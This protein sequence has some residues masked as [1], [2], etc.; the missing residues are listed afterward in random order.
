MSSH[1]SLQGF[2]HPASVAIIGAKDDPNSVGGRPIFYMRRYGYTGRIYPVNPKRVHVQQLTCFPNLNSLPEQPDLVIIAVSAERALTAVEDAVRAGAKSIIMMSSGFGE[3]G[4]AGRALEQKIIR[5]AQ[6]AGV[7][8][9]GPNAQGIA[10][11]S[12]GAI[13]NFSTMFMEIEPEDGPIAIVSQ[14]GAASVM[15]YALLR[16]RGIGARYLAAT[17][18]DADITSS[19]LLLAVLEDPEIKL[20]LLYLESIRETT[21][22]ASAA[23][24]ARRKGVAIVALKSGTSSRG[25]SAASSHTGALATEDA[26]VDAYFRRHGIYRVSDISELAAAAELYLSGRSPGKGR[27]LTM[28]HS[29]AVGVVCADAAEQMGMD[30]ADLSDDTVCGLRDIMPAFGAIHNP[31]DL[32]AGLLSDGSLFGRA[33]E[34]LCDDSNID[35]IHIGM[36]VAGPGYDVNGFAQAARA[37]SDRSGKLILVSGPQLSVLDHFKTQGIPTY[38]GDVEALGLLHQ[39]IQHHRL[40]QQ[41]I[42]QAVTVTELAMPATTLPCLSEAD[43]LKLMTDLG[44]PVVQHARCHD[45]DRA[46]TAFSQIEGKVVLKA[47]SPEIPHKSEYNLVWLGIE[48]QE[49]LVEAFNACHIKLRQLGFPADVIVARQESGR[50]EIVLGARR[51]PVF[52][53]VV[54]IG[55]GG[56]YLEVLKDYLL[57]TPP[58]T[59]VEVLDALQQLRIWP[60]L[61]GVRGD[62]PANLQRLCEAAVQLGNSLIATPAIESVDLNPV[63]IRHDGELVVLDALVTRAPEPTNSDN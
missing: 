53:P 30:F 26:V 33:L 18:N 35:V 15:P 50:R 13:A 25:I 22:L 47:C 19:E 60:I 42:P 36:P 8:L 51:D 9:I 43:S 56:K 21:A 7:P 41:Q 44:I 62:Q 58:F 32:T 46:L 5:M 37:A 59:A 63:L 16:Q 10:N 3:T 57:L 1:F 28:S 39:Y 48:S 17:G 14:S 55:D 49:A 38:Q 6:A 61:Q 4:E 12:N 24:K 11:F 31:L 45:L 52:G 40:L 29:G 2:F 27:V 20:V 34:L 23:E 54:L